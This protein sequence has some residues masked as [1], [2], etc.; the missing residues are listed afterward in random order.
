MDNPYNY[1]KE[2]GV[3]YYLWDSFSR[4]YEKG[5]SETMALDKALEVYDEIIGDPTHI[6]IVEDVYEDHFEELFNAT[7]EN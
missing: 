2:P 1:G 4:S 6:H 5:M 7:K 3:R